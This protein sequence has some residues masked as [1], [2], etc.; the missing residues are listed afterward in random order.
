MI[1]ISACL[2]GVNC[3]YDGGNNKNKEI[4]KL[5]K[6]KKAILV[7]PEQLGG[8]PTSRIPCE[9]VDGN[10]EDVLMNKAKVMDKNGE[11]KTL[12]FIK[13]AQETLKIAKLYGVETAILKA[14]SPSCGCGIIYDGSF[15][16]NKKEGNGV[17]AALLKKEGIRVFDEE[18]FKEYIK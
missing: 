7:C 2:A 12:H 4:L 14:R 9:I 3:R 5:V 10:G 13:G 1:L 17:T 11:D 15:L 18:N 8:L 16:G 6:E